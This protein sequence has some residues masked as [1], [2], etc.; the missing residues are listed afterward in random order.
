VIAPLVN[1]MSYGASKTRQD[2]MKRK[3]KMPNLYREVHKR[4]LLRERVLKEMVNYCT[5]R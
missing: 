1:D 3:L 4:P 5:R 2:K